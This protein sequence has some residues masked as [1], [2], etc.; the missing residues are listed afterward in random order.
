MPHSL[1]SIAAPQDTRRPSGIAR[2]ASAPSSST[3]RLERGERTVVVQQRLSSLPQIR[4]RFREVGPQRHCLFQLGSCLVD[5]VLLG[6][7]FGPQIM[8]MG[9]VRRVSEDLDSAVQMPGGGFGLRRPG[10]GP[11][12]DLRAPEQRRGQDPPLAG[13]ATRAPLTSPAPLRAS[14]SAL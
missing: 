7:D 5:L 2:S 13:N 3:D 12:R 8:R 9:R 14:P 6:V 1:A 4:P 10:A 11:A